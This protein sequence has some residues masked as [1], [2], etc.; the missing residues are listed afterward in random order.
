MSDPV[1]SPDGLLRYEWPGEWAELAI[2]DTVTLT[3][4]GYPGIYQLLWIEDPLFRGEPVY[5]FRPSF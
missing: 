2:G 3:I 1:P 5:V 4:R